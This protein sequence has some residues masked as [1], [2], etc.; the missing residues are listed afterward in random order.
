M[1]RVRGAGTGAPRTRSNSLRTEDKPAHSLSFLLEAGCS[2]L[3]CP[4]EGQSSTNASYAQKVHLQG[5]FADQ[6]E[7]LSIHELCEVR[8]RLPKETTMKELRLS[9]IWMTIACRITR[10]CG[11]CHHLHSSEAN[12]APCWGIHQDRKHQQRTHWLLPQDA[13]TQFL[14]TL[15]AMQAVLL[16]FIFHLGS[17]P[18][19]FQE[20]TQT[21]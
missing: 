18:P 16:K 9:W 10:T 7:Y 14:Y 12:R 20:Y 4:K 19:S 6:M 13:G 15:W 8:P 11:V 1:R 5:L 17:C 21:L 2:L 3:T